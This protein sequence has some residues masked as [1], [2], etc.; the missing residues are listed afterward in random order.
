M[1]AN[2]Q[3]HQGAESQTRR[4][5]KATEYCRVI[6]ILKEGNSIIWKYGTPA[7]MNFQFYMISRIDDVTHR[8][9]S[10][11]NQFVCLFGGCDCSRMWNKSQENCSGNIPVGYFQPTGVCRD[12]PLGSHSVRKYALSDCRNKRVSK[13]EKDQRERWKTSGRVS[14]VY[15]DIEL[16][17][18]DAKG[19]GL[20][21]IGGPCKYQIPEESGLTDAFI[22]EYVTPHDRTKT[23]NPIALVLGRALLWYAFSEAGDADLPLD[24]FRR[25]HDAY[26]EIGNDLPEGTNPVE[27]I[28][29]VITGNEGEVHFDAIPDGL[30]VGND[31]NGAGAGN[32]GA[33]VSLTSLFFRLAENC[34]FS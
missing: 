13:D 26:E 22:L 31:G 9:S 6:E 12:G 1:M 14:D 7:M 28:P 29:L 15:A 21:C 27:K 30:I 4:S 20:L 24:Q 16:S 3:R 32:N 33:G 10:V 2:Y 19:A 11:E 18:P 5:I 17:Y 34:S 8:S 25:I 23:G